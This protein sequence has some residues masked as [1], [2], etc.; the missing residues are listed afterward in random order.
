MVPCAPV[1]KES[2]ALD[3]FDD[4][5]YDF[6]EENESALKERMDHMSDTLPGILNVF[7]RCKEAD[8]RRGL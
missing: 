3:E 7:N 6:L 8:E 4:E 5:Y 2:K 1:C